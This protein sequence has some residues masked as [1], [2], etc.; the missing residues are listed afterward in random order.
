VPLQPLRVS[1][2]VVRKADLIAALRVYVPALADLQV[3]E[4][5]EHFWLM[6]ADDAGASHEGGPA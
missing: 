3:T 4:D 2:V 5:G 1:G 6:L